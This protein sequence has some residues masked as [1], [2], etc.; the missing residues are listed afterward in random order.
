MNLTRSQSRSWLAIS[1]AILAFALAE[2]PRT[3][4][5]QAPMRRASYGRSSPAVTPNYRY[6]T[7]APRYQVQSPG[8]TPALHEGIMYSSSPFARTPYTDDWSTS[9][10]LPYPKPWMGPR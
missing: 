10:R 5:A 4:P 6:A 3:A 8:F 7:P 9:R 1:S 2:A